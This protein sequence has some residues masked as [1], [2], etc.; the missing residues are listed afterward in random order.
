MFG[1]SVGKLEL[2]LE[3]YGVKFSGTCPPKLRASWLLLKEYVQWC[4]LKWLPL[5]HHLPK[6]VGHLLVLGSR[7]PLYTMNY[8]AMDI[9]DWVLVIK[10]RHPAVDLHRKSLP[11]IIG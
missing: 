4:L 6:F 3:S 2:E 8:P 9:R 10:H 11:P 1:Y 5:Y 7:L